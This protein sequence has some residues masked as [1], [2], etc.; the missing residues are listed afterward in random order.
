M[1]YAKTVTPGKWGNIHVLFDN[2][3]YSVISG[4]YEGKHVLGERWN[5]RENRLGFPNQAG[6]PIWHVVPTFL[7]RP[8]LHGLLDELSRTTPAEGSAFAQAILH[9]LREW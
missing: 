4:D 6:H 5:G 9:E 7:A 3:V 2:G 8:V 1:P